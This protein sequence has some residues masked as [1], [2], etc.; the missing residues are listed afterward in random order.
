MIS[1]AIIVLCSVLAGLFFFFFSFFL[2][3]FLKLLLGAERTWLM[4]DCLLEF[5]ERFE[6]FFLSGLCWIL[7]GTV[8]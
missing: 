2:L 6:N 4:L 1:D 8:S 7:L 3:G 5:M